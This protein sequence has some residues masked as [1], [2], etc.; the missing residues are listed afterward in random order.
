[1]FPKGTIAPKLAVGTGNAVKNTIFG[2][3]VVVT[4]EVADVSEVGVSD[5]VVVFA[6]GV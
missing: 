3:G 1:M 2:V 6:V 5:S 4:V